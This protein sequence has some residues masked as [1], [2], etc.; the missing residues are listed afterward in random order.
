MANL[1][2]Y[3]QSL[4]NLSIHNTLPSSSQGIVEQSIPPE[5]WTYTTAPFDGV[6]VIGTE[7]SGCEAVN[8]YC[9]RCHSIA[10]TLNNTFGYAWIP[11]KKGETV[12]TYVNGS[13]SIQLV[14]IP[15]I[16]S[17]L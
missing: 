12:A 9:G 16:Q 15:N 17:S 13:I 4:I 10:P 3:L 14:L 11:I 1:K 5:S 8:I 7:T 6:A 2:T